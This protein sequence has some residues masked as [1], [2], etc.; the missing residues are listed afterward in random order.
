MISKITASDARILKNG[1]NEVYYNLCETIR[2]AAKNGESKLI[3]DYKLSYITRTKLQEDGFDLTSL[4][5][6]K[7]Q[8]WWG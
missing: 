1:A 3:I 6:G 4:E 5:Q 7:H 8:I 2:S